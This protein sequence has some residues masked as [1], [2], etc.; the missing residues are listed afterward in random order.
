VAPRPLPIA[1]T[2]A[3]V[4]ML[5][6]CSSSSTTPDPD[7]DPTCTV[8]AVGVTG[9]P[10]ELLVTATVQLTANVTHANCTTAP[11]VTWSSSNNGRAT[12]SNAGV[13]TGVAAGQVTITAT[14]GGKSGNAS[15]LVTT[16]QVSTVE[17]NPDSLVIGVG[18]G[19]TLSATARD[20]G[21]VAIPGLGYTWL[22]LDPAAVT[23]SAAGQ[24]TGLTAG[25]SGTVTATAV[26]VAGQARVH[27]VRSRFGFFWNDILLPAGEDFPDAS[28]QYRNI[29]TPPTVTRLSVGRYSAAFPG[30]G[31]A[32]H[33]TEAWF[34]SA[35]GG[36]DGAWCR[37]GSWS[38]ASTTLNC[39]DRT[40]APTDMLWTVAMVGSTAFTGR[41]GYAWIQSGAG[42]VTADPE[43]RFNPTGGEIISTR[44]GIGAYTVRLEGLGRTAASDR[45]GVFVSPY[46]SAETTDCR[47]TG[48]TT[49]GAHLD[50]EVRCYTPTG[51]TLDSRFTILVVDMPRP[52][53]RLAF[54]HADQ[55]ATA[56]YSPTNAAV[57]GNGTVTV[58]RTNTG[59]YRVAFTDFYRTAG[60]SE[61]YLV[62]ATGNGMHRCQNTGW[63]TTGAPGQVAEVEVRCRTIGGVPVDAPFS[64]IGLQ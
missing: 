27:V 58:T 21:A 54:A 62:V 6:A 39:L 46:G 52:G 16:P 17:V 63:T 30:S 24:V 11:T 38:A 59:D 61:T 1:F 49:V 60:L 53:A 15:I 20:A 5:G 23:V 34:V 36:P 37:I 55:P 14:A 44:T 47:P 29:G 2:F 26:G 50:V 41:W 33:E 64:I 12:V 56:S 48:W 18:A 22:S 3:T 32:A 40:G 7:P 9:A 19:P 8:S 51:E 28:Y 57:R 45:E 35:Y 31:A 42:T 10:A 43:Y 13:V 4:A 25:S